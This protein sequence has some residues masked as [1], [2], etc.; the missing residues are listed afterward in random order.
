MSPAF[1]DCPGVCH[2]YG[3]DHKAKTYCDNCEVKIAKDSFEEEAKAVL[4]DRLG[5]KWKQY[6][7]DRLLSQV[8]DAFELKNS[9]VNMS[10]TAEIMVGI[11]ISEQ[12]RQRRIE[13]Y[14]RKLKEKE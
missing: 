8:Y 4:D 2:L 12:N 6:K 7:F 3:K 10:I 9:K 1:D 5:D 11:L 13:D 14:N